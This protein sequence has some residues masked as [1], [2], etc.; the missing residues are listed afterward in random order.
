MAEILGLT[1]SIGTALQ[2]AGQ[3]PTLSY[4]YTDSTKLAS[5]DLEDLLNRLSSLTNTLIAVKDYADMNSS[6]YLLQKLNTGPIDA[7]S[8]DLEQLIEKLGPRMAI[9]GRVGRLT[10]PLKEAGVVQF[11]FRIER[12]K[13][14]IILA[15]AVDRR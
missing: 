9:K 14:L 6:S 10:W 12:H 11:I 4:G 5:K 15:L 2:L 7:C 13:S 1:A 3:V 8:Q